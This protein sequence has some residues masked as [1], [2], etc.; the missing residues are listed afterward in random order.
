[1]PATA[2]RPYAGGGTSELQRL[3]DRVEELEILLE[4]NETVKTDV[5]KGPHRRRV[6][7]VA[8]LLL[9]RS[10]VSTGSILLAI[11]CKVTSEKSAGVYIYY[12]R[13]ALKPHAIEIKNHY[14]EGWS[15]TAADKPKLRALLTGK[16]S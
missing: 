9:G 1:M 12:A 2:L 4:L 16:P 6:E 3:R 14:G 13:K 5:F 10:L 15:V 7:T 8:K 11:G